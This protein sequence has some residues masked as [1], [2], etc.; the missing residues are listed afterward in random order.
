VSPPRSILQSPMHKAPSCCVFSLV[1]IENALRGCWF[2]YFPALPRP[3]GGRRGG[4][5]HVSKQAVNQ[6]SSH[7]CHRCL[8]AEW[9]TIGEPHA[10]RNFL[11]LALSAATIAVAGCTTS[12]DYAYRVPAGPNPPPPSGYRVECTSVPAIGNWITNEYKTGCRQIMAPVDQ[13]VVV[14]ARG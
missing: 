3:S 10:M 2:A 14:R 4:R 13:N 7:L 6:I 1:G 12:T 5:P 8:L 9:P 11:G